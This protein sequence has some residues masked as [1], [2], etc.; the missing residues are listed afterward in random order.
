[1]P[2]IQDVRAWIQ[3]TESRRIRFRSVEP[4]DAEFILSLRLDSRL[5]S[6]VSKVEDDI[7]KQRA[8][9]KA[10]KQRE[11]EGRE[12]YFIILLENLPVGTVR[13][14]DFKE[15]SFC[16]G[17]WMI[18]PGTSPQVAVHSMDLVYELGFQVL[19]FPASHFEV[20]QANIRVWTFHEKTGA[21][22]VSATESDRYY[23]LRCE[24]YR[25][26]LKSAFR[27]P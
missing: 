7:E 2:Y 9:I 23:S 19:C 1:M 26:P 16:W 25:S 8:W 20:R 10:Y 5:N 3:S 12:F 24:D 17:S 13:L 18:A 22:L 6:Y 4:E 15:N 14:Y 27:R 11:S 21:K